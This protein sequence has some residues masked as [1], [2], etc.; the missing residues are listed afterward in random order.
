MLACCEP[1]G[2]PA[3]TRH[4]RR[5]C[6]LSKLLVLV[7]A[8]EIHVVGARDQ[9]AELQHRLV[10]GP[11]VHLVDVTAPPPHC[12]NH[13]LRNMLRQRRRG[14]SDAQ[15]VPS[16]EVRVLTHRRHQ[17]L[18]HCPRPPRRASS[19]TPPSAPGLARRAAPAPPPGPETARRQAAAEAP[20]CPAPPCRSC[21]GASSAP[22]T[23]DPADCGSARR[24]ASST[25]QARIVPCLRSR[26]PLP[27]AAR[28]RPPSAPRPSSPPAPCRC[29]GTAA[30]PA[31]ARAAAPP[32]AACGASAHP[33]CASY[34]STSQAASS[35]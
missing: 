35:T 9:L 20:S 11:A 10:R 12:P 32:G 13:H 29:P 28:R 2:T 1:G 7:L 8:L 14:A 31:P 25:L 30:S 18:H 5:S 33:A 23:A 21:T 27:A 16:I 4:P 22:R 15:R 19:P 26:T 34:L 17:R 3:A 24:P 6:S